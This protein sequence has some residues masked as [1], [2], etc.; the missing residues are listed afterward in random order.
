MIESPISD[1]FNADLNRIFGAT[2][3]SFKLPGDRPPRPDIPQWQIDRTNAR[4][5]GRRTFMHTKPCRSCG[6]LERLTHKF[7]AGTKINKCMT[8]FNLERK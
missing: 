2:P 4:S 7:Y 5:V 3:T 8:C 1:R 6:S